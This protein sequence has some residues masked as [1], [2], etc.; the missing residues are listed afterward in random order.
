MGYDGFIV[1]T[2]KSSQK[3]N[4]QK[5]IGNRYGQ[6]LAAEG[7]LLRLAEPHEVNPS[8]K[9]WGFELLRPESGQ[10][11]TRVDNSGNKG[12][13]F[14]AIA[15]A[16]KKAKGVIIS[17]DCDREGQLI[18]EE[19]VEHCRFKGPVLRA[20]FTAEDVKTIR[21]AFE[22]LKPNEE[23]RNLG[24][25]AVARQQA[26]QIFNLT[27]TRAA[28]K[29]F[30]KGRGVIGIGRVKTA[31]MAFVCMRE[32]EIRN[33]KPEDYF[34]IVATCFTEAGTFAMRC[35]PPPERRIKDQALAERIAAA[36]DGHAGPLAVT[37][38]Q[39]RKGPP[40][41][42]DLPGLQRECS[43]RFGW[44]A[45]K[46]LDVAQAVYN[47]EG[48]QL[49]TYPRA[50]TRYY[51]E[52]QIDDIDKTVAA[53][54]HLDV[55]ADLAFNPVVRK[56][57]KGVFSDAG[58]AGVSHTAIAP[59]P[60]T[61][62]ELP[63]RYSRLNADERRLFDL[64]ARRYLAVLMPDYEYEYTRIERQVPVN[65]L[66]E[67]AL[68]VALGEKPLR[69]GWKI[70]YRQAGNLNAEDDDEGGV[71][72]PAVTDGMTGTLREPSIEKKTTR[73]PPRYTEGTL[74]EAMQH[75]WRFVPEDRVELRAKLKEAKGI[76]TSATRAKI[77]KDLKGQN[78][79]QMKGKQFVPSDHALKLYLL[80]RRIAP[81]LVSPA[82]TAVWEMH[83]DRI[84][85]GEVSAQAVIDA[86]AKEAAEIMEKIRQAAPQAG[87][88][89]GDGKSG[90]GP[91]EKMLKAAR[92]VANTL[93]IELPSQVASDFNACKAF[94]DQH[95]EAAKQKAGPAQGPQPPSEKQLAFARKLAEERG[96]DL[97][98][99][100]AKDWRACRAFIDK[101][102]KKKS[103]AKRKAA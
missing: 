33:F 29:A 74:I 3:A 26:D 27:L 86:I 19:I 46:T 59:N 24:Q 100:V 89:A 91:S 60:N 72:L 41:P 28:T 13:K 88:S 36:A 50:E 7:H 84:L 99:E 32:L 43:A 17:T 8:W 11:P 12:R 49:I 15:E 25:A 42:F 81:K 101:N 38:E 75:A 79:L 76:G 98:P 73:P 21:K 102:L 90:N 5:A 4:V 52:A 18:G 62:E 39:K 63:E 16:L 37:V 45:E 92:W 6:I 69:L 35:A 64:V 80:L 10:Y 83:L 47:D 103:S 51:A 58:L 48:K 82:N 65:G 66:A 34:E 20:M 44:S 67:A 68:F 70:L 31:V 95:M 93:N 2:E 77:I 96:V 56:G 40:P 85:K 22:S 9:E 71:L 78:L 53:L 61:I 57:K 55:F 14:K 97:P 87:I 23:Y 54:K 1:I 94:L 30:V